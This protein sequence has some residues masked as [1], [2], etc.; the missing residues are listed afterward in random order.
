MKIEYSKGERAS[1]EL[2]LLNRQQL[3][4]SSGRKN[5]RTLQRML[6]FECLWIFYVTHEQS[7]SD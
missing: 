4:A 2:I 3:D 7:R 1:K 6:V 5:G